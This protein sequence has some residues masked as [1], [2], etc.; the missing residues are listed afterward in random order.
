MSDTL[1]SIVCLGGLW[2]FVACTILLILKGFPARDRFD[3]LA[4]AKWG[5]GALICFAAWVVGMTQA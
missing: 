3:R 1:W 5:A 4:A 2:G